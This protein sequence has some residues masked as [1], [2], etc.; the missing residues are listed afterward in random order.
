M[1]QR[2]FQ[3]NHNDRF[4]VK[5]P[6]KLAEQALRLSEERFASFSRQP[7]LRHPPL[8]NITVDVNDAFVNMACCAERR[9][10]RTPATCSFGWL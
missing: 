8:E 2:T 6:T 4:G 7:I 10:G 9:H 3:L 5:S 1:R